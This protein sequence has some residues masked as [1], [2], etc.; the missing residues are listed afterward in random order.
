MSFSPEPYTHNKGRIEV[1]FD[2]SN[3]VTEFHLKNATG[4][5]TSDFAKKANLTK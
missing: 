2:L 4:I 5:Y 3:Y 1:E